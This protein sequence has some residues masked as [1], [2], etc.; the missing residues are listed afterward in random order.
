M[1][2]ALRALAAVLEYGARKYDSPPSERGWLKY[3]SEE[4]MGSLMHHAE[5]IA[6]GEIIDSGKDGSGL[7]HVYHLHFNSAVLCDHYHSCHGPDSSSEIE[8]RD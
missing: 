2:G 1:P 3:D 5:A 8:P 6:N 7:P 4:V